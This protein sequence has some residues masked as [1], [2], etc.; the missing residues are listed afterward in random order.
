MT[1]ASA[2]PAAPRAASG[3][4]IRTGAA[5]MTRA[6]PVTAATALHALLDRGADRPEPP[7]A[8]PAP[9]SARCP[10][11]AESIAP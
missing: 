4:G 6:A 9:V 11:C 1:E 7:P 5:A 8:R 2:L 3:S 10:P